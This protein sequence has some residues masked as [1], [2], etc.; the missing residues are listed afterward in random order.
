MVYTHL[1]TSVLLVALPF[2][3]SA[4]LAIAVYLLREGLVQMDVPARQ[5]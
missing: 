2:V 4:T 3:P 1:P 5:S